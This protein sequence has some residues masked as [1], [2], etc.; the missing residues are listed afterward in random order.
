MARPRQSPENAERLTIR[1]ESKLAERLRVLAA[2][3]K[4]A[5]S[6]LAEE[7]LGLYIRH[8]ERAWREGIGNH[9]EAFSERVP[10]PKTSATWSPDQVRQELIRLD[11]TQAELAAILDIGPALLS[12]WLGPRGIPF[13]RQ[14]GLTEAI[15]KLRR[16]QKAQ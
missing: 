11:A 5:M 1:L 10:G 4:R 13:R 9:P 12:L 2:R 7:A 6:A 15:R 16:K 14:E 3:Q 8:A